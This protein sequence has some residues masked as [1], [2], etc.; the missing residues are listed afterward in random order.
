MGR[1][2]SAIMA[3]Q[4]CTARD[5][6]KG[7]TSQPRAFPKN[8]DMISIHYGVPSIIKLHAPRSTINNTF[9]STRNIALKPK[10]R[11]RNSCTKHG[12]QFDSTIK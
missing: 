10:Q 8:L 2:R 1:Q 9:E 7:S 5:S 6:A 12:T 3:R 4:K 11:N